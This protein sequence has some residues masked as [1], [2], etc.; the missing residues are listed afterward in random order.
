MTT[1]AAF[2][3]HDDSPFAALATHDLSEITDSSAHVVDSYCLREIQEHIDELER[4]IA[5]L[6][7]QCQ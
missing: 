3:V 2:V 5:A 1:E 7:A 4:R 6:E